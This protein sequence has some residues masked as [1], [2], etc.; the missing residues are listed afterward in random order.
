MPHAT[1]HEPRMELM[2][3]LAAVPDAWIIG[4][5]I[6]QCLF[7]FCVTIVIL[8]LGQGQRRFETLEARLQEQ[9]TL[10]IDGKFASMAQS[11]DSRV[12]EFKNTLAGLT[13]TLKEAR[14]NVGELYDGDHKIELKLLE[15]VQDLHNEIRDQTAER[16][17]ETVKSLNELR[18]TM[19]TTDVL[20]RELER[21]R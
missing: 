7:S 4:F 15:K 2:L 19:V 20:R 3:F 9:A 16:E 12:S 5:G 18:A 1:D 21:A 10:A 6:F 8:K 17:R 13:E 11:L 14:Q